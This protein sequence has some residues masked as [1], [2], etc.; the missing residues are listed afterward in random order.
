V[1]TEPVAEPAQ[2]FSANNA[3][4]AAPIKEEMKHEI[5]DEDMGDGYSAGSGWNNRGGGGDDGYGPINVKED[6]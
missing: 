6:G 5:K 3:E 4:V 1:K 2:G